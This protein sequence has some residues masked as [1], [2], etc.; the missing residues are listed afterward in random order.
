MTLW[1]R[2]RGQQWSHWVAARGIVVVPGG[3]EVSGTGSGPS[4]WGQGLV[5]ITRGGGLRGLL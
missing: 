3:W 5:V 2:L 1:V 4:G